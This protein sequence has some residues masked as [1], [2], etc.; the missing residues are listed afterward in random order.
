MDILENAVIHFH[1]H[2]NLV[3]TGRVVTARSD[4]GL[5]NRFLAARGPVVVQNDLAIHVVK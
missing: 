1:F 2:G 5:L 3:A 4:V